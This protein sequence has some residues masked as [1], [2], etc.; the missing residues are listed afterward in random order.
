MKLDSANNIYMIGIKGQGMT[1]L[2][3]IL[4]S[5]GKIISWSDTDEK[6]NTDEVEAFSI[7]T[8]QKNVWQKIT[9]EVTEFSK[10]KILFV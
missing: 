4:K 2:A 7:V 1:G 9:S 5:Q 6:F 3:L 10:A 8:D